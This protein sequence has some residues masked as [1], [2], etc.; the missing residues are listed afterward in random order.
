ML[1]TSTIIMISGAAVLFMVAYMKSPRSAFRGLELT[2]DL[3]VQVTP[4]LLAAFVIA[5]MVQVLVPQEVVVQWMG[6]ESGF[7]GILIGTALGGLTPGGPMTHFPILA[8]FYQ[9]GIGVGPLIAYLTAWLLF[10]LQRVV[11]WE[12]PFLGTDIVA[13]RLASSFFLPVF[14]GWF[15]SILW[16]RW[17]PS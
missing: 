15:A 8:S 14:S 11:M 17:H 9:M 16:N 4:R 6:K 3:L 10:G 12:L 13:V 1:D 5:G 7:R 2:R